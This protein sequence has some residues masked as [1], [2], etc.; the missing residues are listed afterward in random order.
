[1]ETPQFV[2][3]V[4][5]SLYVL[6]AFRY[7]RHLLYG[8]RVRFH[9]RFCG[10]CFSLSFGVFGSCKKKKKNRHGNTK[11]PLLPLEVA[12][13]PLQKFP[14]DLS[15]SNGS[16]LSKMKMPLPPSNM[17]FQDRKLSKTLIDF[18]ARPKCP[19]GRFYRLSRQLDKNLG[20]FSRVPP[21]N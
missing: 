4:Q 21:K 12:L 9:Q 2:F 17:K 8:L 7:S 10:F 19:Y 20:D 3:T 13:V 11:R 18:K 15:F 1:M 5:K 14:P 6:I 16:A